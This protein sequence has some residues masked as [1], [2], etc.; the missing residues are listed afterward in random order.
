MIKI[1]KLIIVSFLLSA[2]MIKWEMKLTI[3][4]D[5]SGFYSLTAGIDEE[6]QIFALEMVQSSLGGLDKVLDSVPEG[7]GKSFYSDE[8]Y[9]G[10]TLRNSFRNIDELSNQISQLKSNPDT[11]LM[12]IPIINI[13][14]EKELELSQVN[15]RVFGEFA[16]IIESE[17]TDSG[18]ETLLKDYLYDL[19][20]EVTLPGKMT[21]PIKISE[22]PNTVI[23][24]PSG[25]EFQTFEALSIEME[26]SDRRWD[27]LLI[28]FLLSGGIVALLIIR[29]NK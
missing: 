15:Y 25:R 8:I 12:L 5:L 28:S 13:N 18:T 3:N 27:W 7:Y 1:F 2:C 22:G 6:L 17:V 11:A 26:E 4:E 24:E 10:I 14:I 21:I 29:K 19:K 20:L 16:E 23:F 9:D